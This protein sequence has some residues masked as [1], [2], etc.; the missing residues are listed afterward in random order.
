MT[1]INTTTFTITDPRE[2][3]GDPFQVAERAIQQAQ[4]LAALAEKSLDAAE[5]MARNAELERSLLLD[6]EASLMPVAAGWPESPQG[7][8]IDSAREA[9]QT[10]QRKLK[11]VA[12]AAAFN[13]KA[14]IKAAA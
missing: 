2:F 14:R 1:Q 4:A 3:D 5:I 9:L 11:V 7:R 13:P 10:S 12:K 8:M 6:K